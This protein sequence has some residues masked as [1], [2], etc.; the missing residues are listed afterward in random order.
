MNVEIKEKGKNV[1]VSIIGH[2]LSRY[3][4]TVMKKSSLPLQV[5]LSLRLAL[6]MWANRRDSSIWNEL[7][8]L[9]TLFSILAFGHG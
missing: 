7:V 6:A 4:H 9:N 3:G 2:P 5:R 1:V 8:C